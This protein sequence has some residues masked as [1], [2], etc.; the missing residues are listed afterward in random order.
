[1]LRCCLSISRPVSLSFGRASACVDVFA[2][3]LMYVSIFSCCPPVC[4]NVFCPAPWPVS[5]CVSVCSFF[6][7]QCCSGRAEACANVVLLGR[8][9]VSMCYCCARVCVNVLRPCAQA[10]VNRACCLGPVCVNRCPAE[11]LMHTCCPP[12]PLALV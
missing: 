12:Q 4:V 9:S 8:L 6:P 5:T 1:M 2:P 7:C 3:L 10:C 11:A